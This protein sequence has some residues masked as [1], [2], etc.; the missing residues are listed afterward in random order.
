MGWVHFIW[1][2]M[3]YF[4]QTAIARVAPERPWEFQLWSA[5]Q[6]EYSSDWR[7]CMGR[8]AVMNRAAFNGFY[9]Y[10]YKIYSLLKFYVCFFKVLFFKATMYYI[11]KNAHY[12]K[13]TALNFHKLNTTE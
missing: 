4:G 1:Q 5:H 12:P 10:L 6:F 8:Q 7:C 2:L 13:Y 11:Y 9:S 3:T